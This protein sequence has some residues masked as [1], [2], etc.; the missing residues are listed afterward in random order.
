MKAAPKKL[1][2]IDPM[3]PMM[4]MKS[5]W[6][7]RSTENAAGSH[8]P[9]WTKPHRAPAT[10]TKNEL[11]AKAESLAHIGRMPMTSAATSMSRIAIH[12][13]PIEA[14]VR[15]FAT[16]RKHNQQDQAEEVFL[17]RRFDWQAEDLKIGH[18]YRPGRGVIGEPL[19]AQEGPVG[20]ELCGQRGYRQIEAA[21]P[22]AGNAEQDAHAGGRQPAEDQRTEQRHVRDADQEIVGGIGADRHEGAGTQR[23]LPT[24]A[25]Q[26]IHPER[27]QRQDQERDQDGAEVILVGHE[28][29]A[30]EGEGDDRQNQIAILGNREYLL[31]S[32]VGSLELAVFAVDH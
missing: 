6:N 10:P 4:T 22:Q 25:D 19:D 20:N 2:T 7:E 18:R 28:G 5:S 16:R 8:E 21:H 9:R 29:N 24:V 26:Q 1:P 3:P 17:H 27:G 32:P 30:D 12:C 14:R 15:F 13:R 23:D 11:T 31:V